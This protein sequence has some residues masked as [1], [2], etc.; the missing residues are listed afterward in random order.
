V[1]VLADETEL[2]DDRFLTFRLGR[3]RSNHAPGFIMYG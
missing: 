1:E 2:G 3:G